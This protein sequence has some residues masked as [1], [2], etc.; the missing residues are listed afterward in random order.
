MTSENPILPYGRQTITEDDI[1]A[2]IEVLRSPYITQGPELTKFEHA[3]SS[4]VK[5]KYGLLAI[6][7]KCIASWMPCI[8]IRTG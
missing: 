4:K 6:A 7:L 3:I 8:G 5:A 2:V 1:S